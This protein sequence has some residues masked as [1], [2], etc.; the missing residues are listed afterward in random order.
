MPHTISTITSAFVVTLELSGGS[1]YEYASD[2]PA[3]DACTFRLVVWT[4]NGT[5]ESVVEC[6]NPGRLT[7]LAA[8]WGCS[9]TL[10][11][12]TAVR[13]AVIADLVGL[14]L[15]TRPGM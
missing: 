15:A 9:V 1:D 12:R 2:V 14:D 10:R 7:E 13:D 8:V 6:A 5:I 4:A 11:D 3:L